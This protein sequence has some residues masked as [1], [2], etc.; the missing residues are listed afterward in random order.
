MCGRFTRFHKPEEIAER[1]DVETIEEAAATLRYNI[2]PSQIVPVIR[3]VEKREMIACKWGLVPFWAKDP[4]IGYK[5]INAKGETLAQKPAFKNA[6]TRRRC[7]V[8]AD[9]FYE[10]LKQ[11]KG[12]KQP[13]YIRLNGN[14]LFAF[15]G[16]YEDWKSPEGE[17]LRTFTIITVEPNE[18][19]AKIHNRMPA[20]L[21]PDE[22]SVWLDPQTPVTDMA[23]LLRPYPASEMETYPVSRT[24]NSP[25]ID[26]PSCIIQSNQ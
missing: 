17:K 20:I 22:E 14:E 3:Q 5:M 23:S 11:E 2:A 6:L 25:L 13:I 10:W 16:L 12:V 4:K 9:G 8:P 7:L 18:L 19:I 26:D 1:F 21:R 24:V 15:A